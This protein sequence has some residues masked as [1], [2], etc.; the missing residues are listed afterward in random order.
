MSFHFIQLSVSIPAV[1]RHLKVTGRAG[2][3][4]KADDGLLIKTALNETFGQKDAAGA[5]IWPKPFQVVG[6]QQNG[7]ATVVAYSPLSVEDLLQAWHPMPSLAAAIDRDAVFGYGMA[8]LAQGTRQRFSVT[9]CPMLSTYGDRSRGI[10]PIA[11]DAYRMEHMRAEKEGREARPRGEVYLDFLRRRLEPAVAIEQVQLGGF[12]LADVARDA[13]GA[14]GDMSIKVPVA[15]MHGV[16][17]VRDGA[18][19]SQLLRTGI[20][21]RRAYGNGMILIGA[22]AQALKAA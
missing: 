22:S 20:G 4:R 19:F 3:L 18:A 14:K 17:Q 15:T 9:F 2:D 11:L 8:D 13:P 1:I 16:L 21:K 6:R 10:K 5:Q 12:T 7:T